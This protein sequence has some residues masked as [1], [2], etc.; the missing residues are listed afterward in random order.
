MSEKI[1]YVYPV[2]S[3]EHN[4]ELLYS[5]R[6]VEKNG[7]PNNVIITGHKPHWLNNKVIYIPRR[8]QRS[9]V[10][11]KYYQSA[12]NLLEACRDNRVGDKFVQMNDD[13]FIMR[14]VDEIKYYYRAELKTVIDVY[15]QKFPNSPYLTGMKNTY[16][17]LTSMG[18]KNPLSYELHVPMVY[19]KE[20]RLELF[21]IQKPF[22]E[23]GMSIHTRTM[24]GNIY[25]VGGER[26]LDVKV[27]YR[28]DKWDT[29]WPYLS[30]DESTF[31]R[32]PAG[33]YIQNKFKVKS[34]YEL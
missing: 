7:N 1:D 27:I 9:A 8:Q 20:K 6:S 24:Y 30:T 17:I 4:P 25:K 22:L 10:K 23:K 33:R 29:S 18:F 13:F 11:N 28:K 3:G 32:I 19:E 12:N 31:Y 2:R 26:L 14:P 5:I 34:K 15:S 21:K 16:K